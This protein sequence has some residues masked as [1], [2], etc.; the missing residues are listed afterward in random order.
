MSGDEGKSLF[1]RAKELAN[2]AGEVVVESAGLAADSAVAAGR[3]AV[4]AA[5]RVE[6]AIE[7]HFDPDDRSEHGPTTGGAHD[8]CSCGCA[9]GPPARPTRHTGDSAGTLDDSPITRGDLTSRPPATSWPGE[10]K[11]SQLPFLFLRANAGDTGSRPAAGAFWESPDVLL[12][13]G[14]A[15]SAA[16][17]VPPA[18]GQVALA[19]KP[20]TVYAHVWN[21]GY[22]AAHDITV[23]FY[24][25]DPTLGINGASAQLIGRKHTSLGARGSGHA[26]RIVKCPKPWTPTFVNGGHECLLVRVWDH[27]GDLLTTPE[28][29]AAVNR[30]LGQR[31]VHV[32]EPGDP[33]G[34]P[35]TIQVGPLFGV[36]TTV[37]VERTHPAAVPWLQQRTGV[38]GMFPAPAPVTGQVGIGLQGGTP[39]DRHEV[40]GDDAHVVLTATD[41]PPPP[42][43]AHV[44]RV[45]AT[46]GG[47]PFGGYTVVVLG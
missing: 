22:A 27:C 30:H 14:V 10:R 21:F 35:I 46:A 31:N 40:H 28:W 3:A 12:L 11:D 34:A 7:R 33:V 32:N 4:E 44:Y 45:T 20:N 29:D 18:L 13:A 23:E 42:G 15:P 38:R 8:G 43:S 5:D 9:G 1:Q 2:R 6:D 26:H 16:P 24:W 47:A 19:G 41:D 36:P 25:C 39:A 37:T 17:P